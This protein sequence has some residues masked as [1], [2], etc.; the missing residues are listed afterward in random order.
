MARDFFQRSDTCS[1]KVL[2]QHCSELWMSG[3][4]FGYYGLTSQLWARFNAE[5]CDL[6]P[7]Q[8]IDVG[9]KNFE[10]ERMALMSPWISFPADVGF[11]L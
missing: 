6:A 8:P 1:N 11:L 7:C 5:F 2:A 3:E 9:F 10:S 4:P